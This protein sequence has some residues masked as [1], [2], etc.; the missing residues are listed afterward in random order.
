MTSDANVVLLTFPARAISPTEREILRQSLACADDISTAYTTERRSDD[1]ALY[2]RIV[3]VRKP[4]GHPTYLIHQP[5]ELLIGV[6]TVV[7]PK[8]QIV[9]FDT[10]RAA[11]TGC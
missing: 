7:G 4:R 2:R 8:G 6:K 11:P 3:V 1:P 5:A 9:T 10:L